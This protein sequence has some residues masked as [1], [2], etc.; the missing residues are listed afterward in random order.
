MEPYKT[1]QLCS[2]LI[3]EVFNLVSIEISKTKTDKNIIHYE[4]KI[5]TRKI[6]SNLA[7]AQVDNYFKNQE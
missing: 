4:S 7:K 1:L 3:G 5:I 2:E 6:L